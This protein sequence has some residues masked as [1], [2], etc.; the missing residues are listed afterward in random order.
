M[1]RRNG[2]V[3]YHGVQYRLALLR[4][5]CAY[6]V[7][8]TIGGYDFNQSERRV[9]LFYPHIYNGLFMLPLFPSFSS[10][11]PCMDHKMRGSFFHLLLCVCTL[12][13]EVI[14]LG[15]SSANE[16]SSRGKADR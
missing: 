8:R 3:F 7:L 15:F 13:D 11:S 14:V 12:P 5:V 16:L 10:L 4:N 2:L 9:S 1:G 6:T